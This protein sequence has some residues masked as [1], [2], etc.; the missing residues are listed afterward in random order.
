M[1]SR[2]VSAEANLQLPVPDS[3]QHYEH[4][5]DVQLPV[6]KVSYLQKKDGCTYLIKQL[7]LPR[8]IEWSGKVSHIF[9]HSL[10]M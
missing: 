7:H 6:N 5:K 8:Q 2:L 10:E 4:K 3:M 9:E 1:R